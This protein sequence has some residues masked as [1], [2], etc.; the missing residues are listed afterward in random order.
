MS[1]DLDPSHEANQYAVYSVVL[2]EIFSVDHGHLLA[3]QNE[4]QT[5]PYDALGMTLNGLKDIHPKVS[6]DAL[7]DYVEKIEEPVALEGKFDSRLNYALVN[8]LPYTNSEDWT[9]T[10]FSLLQQHPGAKGIISFSRVGFS[11]NMREAFLYVAFSCPLCSKW[12]HVHLV[13][14]QGIWKIKEIFSGFRT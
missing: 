1:S 6:P 7:E 9:S 11:P 14:E 2:N 10:Y 3:I 4:T 12:D 8:K 13:K 5:P